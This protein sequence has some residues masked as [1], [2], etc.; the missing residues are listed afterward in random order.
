MSENKEL[1]MNEMEAVSGGKVAAG[2]MKNKPAPK[3]GYTVHH[4]TNTDT[5]WDLSRKY[6]TTID[7]IMKANPTIKDR[8]LIRTGYYLYIPNA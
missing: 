3:A 6:N 7:A 1:N 2:G 4:I 5:L 8:N